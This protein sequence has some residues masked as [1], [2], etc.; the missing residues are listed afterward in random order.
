M[1]D[2]EYNA[3][4]ENYLNHDRIKSAIMLT[5]PWGMG[6]SYF[7][8]NSLIPYLEKNGDRKCVV[9]S[10]YGLNDIKE[11]SK[12]IYL[13]MRV[14][15]TNIKG[16]KGEAGKIVAKTI[17]KNGLSI[18]GID[19]SVKEEDLEKLYASID[20]SGKLIILEDLE[21]SSISIKQV[22]GYVNNLV[23]HDGVKVLLIAN[24]NEIKKSYATKTK[25]SKGEEVTKW[26]YTDET[27]E[28]LKIK[29]KTVSDTILYLCDYDAA[30]ESILKMF[31]DTNIN[32][33]LENRDGRGKAIIVGE[34][35]N[36]MT[37][38]Q[39]Y[40]LR[41]LIFAC[42]KTV[43]IFAN[44]TGNLD[45]EFFQHVFLGNL[46]FSLRLKNNDGLKW[47]NKTNPN[48]LGTSKYP[49]YKFCHEY[50]KYQELDVTAIK[51]E[52]SAFRE[53]KEYEKKQC[54]ANT[55]LSI[56]YDFPMQEEIVLAS[57]VKTIRDE[58]KDGRVIP[59]M[60]YGKL[61]NY[62]IV[63]KC[64]LGNPGLIDECKSIMLENIK[65]ATH[66]DDKVFDRL[67]VHDR[68]GF[69]EASQDKEY[70]EFIK[71]MSTMF[72]CDIFSCSEGEEPLEYLKKITELM[73]DREY[74]VHRNSSFMEQ[75]EIEKLLLA[76]EVA[77]AEQVSDFRG[78]VLSVYR[79]VNISNFLPNDKEALAE[80]KDG[81]QYLLDS[82]KGAD[83]VIRL[84]YKWLVSNLETALNNY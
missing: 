79:S 64:V 51:I 19:L 70:N 22:L 7:I 31:A 15:K 67:R 46:A 23:E 18:A 29:E 78:G 69:W 24:E 41:S 62:L 44:Y 74:S 35:N 59:L 39:I 45:V 10:L 2:L 3:H 38:I 84:Q 73:C 16:E 37:D 71:E 34:I 58:L 49:L 68:F 6:K 33:C 25:N 80:L 36:V 72:Q 54:E 75:V 66:K 77:T 8:Q 9:V 60:Q 48:D 26:I 12:A 32:R 61:A 81:V 52:Q 55:A 20:L 5:A 57:A 50:I 83:R 65:K 40:N 63:V 56:L 43:D 27:E 14:K 47:D 76:L 13:E 28:Y 21:R 42:Q 4:I 82:G 30:I 11:I 53:K 17:L 1:N